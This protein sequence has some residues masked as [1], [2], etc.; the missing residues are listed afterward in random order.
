M[1]KTTSV[2]K[3]TGWCYPNK[4]TQYSEFGKVN[5]SSCYAFAN[6]D[7]IKK[8]DG[9]CAYIPANGGVNE[10]HDSPR[11]Y[12][13]DYRFN[14]PAEAHITK[15][16]V[17]QRRKKGNVGTST[18]IKDRLIKLK[19]GADVSKWGVG[20]DQSKGM[21]WNSKN[22]GLSDYIAGETYD[23]VQ[24]IWGIE[25][26]PY[27]ANNQNFG[28]IVQCTGT[29]K[30][31]DTPEIDSVGMCIYYKIISSETDNDANENSNN[32]NTSSAESNTT[33]LS[34][35]QSDNIMSQ[36]VKSYQPDDAEVLQTTAREISEDY[37]YTP[38][39][40]W[41]Q[42]RSK[43][44]PKSGIINEGYNDE[45][46]LWCDSNLQFSNGTNKIVFPI[47][48]FEEITDREDIQRGYVTRYT[49]IK[50][51]P[52]SYNPEARIKAY[53]VH[54]SENNT[55]KREQTIYLSVG[56][57]MFNLS[58]ST[59]ELNKCT[60][61]NCSAVN[62]NSIYNA[63]SLTYSNLKF[64]TLPTTDKEF[65]DYDKYRDGEFR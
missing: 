50:V 34:R 54:Y 47:Y 11:I 27:I 25:V 24:S 19:V 4:V 6:L 28:C 29:G 36:L 35:K 41:L 60:F 46:R 3:N 31:F 65:W 58:S 56:E 39:I 57:S 10:T 53:G 30:T 17:K 23:T 59:T 51:F 26:T 63:G 38:F 22:K 55:I 52:V 1:A 2:V 21:V 48:H 15:V 7:R 18:K 62:G 5:K 33:P 14:I 44:N 12:C 8:E 45:I 64:N 43:V 42:Y 20:T 16:L 61:N 32:N 40:I 13:Y 9:L 49:W 37:C